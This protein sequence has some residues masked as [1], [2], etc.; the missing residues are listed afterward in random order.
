M[1]QFEFLR[2]RKGSSVQP[3]S[4]AT[5]TN[6]CLAALVLYLAG[7]TVLVPRALSSTSPTTQLR[8]RYR[9]HLFD[10]ATG[11]FF[12]RTF[13][14]SRGQ[15]LTPSRRQGGPPSSQAD[16]M[17]Y[18]AQGPGELAYVHTRAN[19]DDIVAAV[20]ATVAVCA[21]RP[22]DPTAAL[23]KHQDDMMT[24]SRESGSATNDGTV[25]ASEKGAAARVVPSTWH[26]GGLVVLHEV[27]ETHRNVMQR[28]IA[29]AISSDAYHLPS[30]LY[31]LHSQPLV[32]PS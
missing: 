4:Y 21:R 10:R 23:R 15:L 27:C 26:D 22:V 28:T 17:L 3:Y 13:V 25:D 14:T 9:I 29:P 6:H 24:A 2:F 12:G 8:L 7:C 31:A 11:V 30:T 19:S 32:G 1:F 5:Q 18:D 20:E 16:V